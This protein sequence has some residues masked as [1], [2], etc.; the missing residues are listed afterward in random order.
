MSWR[1]AHAAAQLRDEILAT[2]PG[3]TIWTLGDPAHA[4]RASDHN[5]NDAGVVCAIDVLED[6]RGQAD[7]IWQ[8]LAAD[9]DRRMHYAIHDGQIIS[10][11]VQ[12]GKVRRYSGSNP[13]T[14]HVH[15]SVGRGR[16]GS[17]HTPDLYDDR[18][19]WG[20]TDYLLPAT[21]GPPVQTGADWPERTATAMDTVTLDRVTA[22][23]STHVTSANV[24]RLQSLLAAGGFPPARSFTARGRPDGVG[25]PATRAALERFQTRH[26]DTGS[27]GRP[28]AIAGPATWSTLLGV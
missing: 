13:H 9:L 24:A 20:L 5:P 23:R 26:P 10:N 2:W 12:P 16:D 14:G 6:G 19:P 11:T 17:K 8:H 1:T 25:G 22:A 21:T 28:D 3:T 15:I 27:N 7:A 18:S 4:S